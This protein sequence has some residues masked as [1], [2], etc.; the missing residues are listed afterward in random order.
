[1]AAL[2]HAWLLSID[3]RAWLLACVAAGLLTGLLAG[4]MLG[5]N[6]GS[7]VTSADEVAHGCDSHLDS[8][9]VANNNDHTVY[10]YYL[11]AAMSAATDSAIATA[12]GLPGI[13]VRTSTTSLARD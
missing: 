5:T 7:N 9:C 13:G 3:G 1:M 10:K 4:A 11:G 8:Q 6:F 12:N 2:A